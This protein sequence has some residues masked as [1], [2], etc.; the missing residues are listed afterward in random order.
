VG[1][2]KAHPSLIRLWLKI[3]F[4]CID[5]TRFQLLFLASCR[6]LSRYLALDG[7][8]D[9]SVGPFGCGLSVG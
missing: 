3:N 7:F 5:S 8:G 4:F 2:T 9:L 1:S 6:L